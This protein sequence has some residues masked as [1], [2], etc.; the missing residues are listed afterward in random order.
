MKKRP[1]RY[2]MVGGGV[3]SFIG[4]VH[5]KAIAIDEMAE[6]T[7]GCFS[8]HDERNKETETD[9]AWT[10]RE[11]IPIIVRWQKE[12]MHGR[13]ELILFRLLRLMTHI[14]R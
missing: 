4:G 12:K 14:M 5:R 8:D 6:L 2:G 13:M 1:L 11:F 7:A 9:M 3:G 10:K